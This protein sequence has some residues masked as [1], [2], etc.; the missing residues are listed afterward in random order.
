MDKSGNERTIEHKKRIK[1]LRQIIIAVVLVMLLLPTVLSIVAL[2]RISSLN[3]RLN[4]ITM[5]L[6]DMNANMSMS[7]HESEEPRQRAASGPTPLTERSLSVSGDEMGETDDGYEGI[8]KVYLTFDDGPSQ[9][10]D[11][12]LDIL[13]EYDV[14]ATFFVNG[15]EGREAEYLRIALE[16]HSLGMHS[17]SHE[18]S[19]VYSDLDG[20]AEDLHQIQQL[21]KDIT[22]E[23]CLLYRFPG[24]SS[25]AVHR[26]PMAEC[27]D[28]LD[29]K[30]IRYFD[31]N[32]SG[33]DAL[34]E[35]HSATQIVNDVCNQ[36]RNID[37]DTVVVLLHDA[38]GKRST[39][40]ALPMIIEKLMSMDD[41]VLLPITDDT[42]DVQH[43]RP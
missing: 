30:R 36:V 35:P 23:D 18:Y 2:S 26:M 41:V 5:L 38:P 10:T 7:T 42:K 19:K 28:Y 11:E 31:W 32:V 20:F 29:A 40:E 25:N 37:D 39:V 17:Y 6:S 43:V 4:E 27:I 12:I 13:A 24:G 16:G 34:A 15:H 3:D 9:Y 21:L 14:K 8:K 1:Q 22:G 33:G